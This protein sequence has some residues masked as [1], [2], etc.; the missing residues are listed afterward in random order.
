MFRSNRMENQ[1]L[2]K[3][4][5]LFFTPKPGADA[6]VNPLHPL[7]SV[8]I[9]HTVLGTYF[10]MPIRRICLTI[11]SFLVSDHFFYSCNLSV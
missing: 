11:K 2:K 10:I 5:N 8:H 9:L 7:V 3:I 1:T 4:Q 6:D